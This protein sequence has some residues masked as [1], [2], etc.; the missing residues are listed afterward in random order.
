MPMGLRDA[1]ARCCTP[2][3]GLKVVAI[4]QLVVSLIIVL[5]GLFFMSSMSRALGAT[6]VQASV[7]YNFITI[8]TVVTYTIMFEMVFAILVLIGINHK[9]PSLIMSYLIFSV[10]MVVFCS[11]FFISSAMGATTCLIADRKS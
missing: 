1:K 11:L 6:G 10:V 4:I 9:I 5:A 3:V 7:S 8:V 2:A